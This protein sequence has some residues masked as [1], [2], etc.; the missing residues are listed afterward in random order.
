MVVEQ[1]G[2]FLLYAEHPDFVSILQ[3][4]AAVS[5]L[6]AWQLRRT[7]EG[8]AHHYSI[9]MH[10]IHNGKWL[11]EKECEAVCVIRLQETASGVWSAICSVLL[12]AYGSGCIPRAAHHS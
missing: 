5:R 4:G 8:I 9:I 3:R 2:D 11:A 10:G 6:S 1:I 7:T 12:E